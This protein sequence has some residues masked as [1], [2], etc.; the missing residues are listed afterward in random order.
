M[1]AG[2]RHELPDAVSLHRRAGVREEGRL[3]ECDLRQVPGDPLFLEDPVNHRDVAARPGQAPAD[4]PVEICL[5]RRQDLQDRIVDGDRD[6]VGH[7]PGI[8]RDR[9][10]R[11]DDRLFGRLGLGD[12]RQLGGHEAV[13]GARLLRRSRKRLVAERA[14]V[15]LIG[16]VEKLRIRGRRPRRRPQCVDRPGEIFPGAVEVSGERGFPAAREDLRGSRH[17]DV[18]G[19]RAAGSRRP[20]GVR[21]APNES[22]QPD[23][24]TQS[25]T[26]SPREETWIWMH[27]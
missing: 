26:V 14:L 17:G 15:E 13:G 9:F 8:A 21:R 19:R 3:D 20:P 2:A 6:V 23:Q 12:L 1:P 5:E 4:D 27:W 16:E 11:V 25:N 7:C 10:L 18:R 24:Q 22:G